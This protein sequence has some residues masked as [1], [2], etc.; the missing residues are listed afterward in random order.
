MIKK[1]MIRVVV[2][3]TVF[4]TALFGISKLMNRGTS[5]TTEE[6]AAATL[7]LVYMLHGDTQLNCLRGYVKTMDVIAMRD[8]LTPMDNERTV[9]IQVEKFENKIN[10]ISF[11]ILSSDGKKSLEN[12]KVTK[13]TEDENYVTATLELQNK[14]LINTEYIMKI[15][16]SVGNREIYY[17]TRII[18]EDG[19]HVKEYLDFV[20]GF[21]ERCLNK[22]EEAVLSA[23]IEPNELGD[24]TT[25]AHMDIHSSYDQLTWNKLNPQVYYKPIPSIREINQTTA[26]IVMDYMIST[27]NENN[28]TELYHVSEYYRMRFTESRIM[29]NNFERNTREIFNP[30]DDV[31]TREGINLGIAGK[32]LTY[33]N[34]ARNNFFAFVQEG[35]LWLYDVRTRRLAQVFSFPQ[36]KNLGVR[37]TY[38]QN[39]IQI[40]SIDTQGNVYFLVCGYMNRGKHEGESGVVVYYYDAAALNVKECLFVDTKRAYP[41]LKQDVAALSYVNKERDI[42]YI[43]I[44]GEVYGIHMETRQVSNLVSDLKSGCHGSSKSGQQ[45]AWMKEN[46][47]YNSKTIS[48]MDLETKRVREIS[49]QSGERL[50]ILGFIGEDLIYGVASESDIDITHN[51]NEIFPMN[52][53]L[54]VNPDGKTVKEYN[55]QGCY[56]KNVVI[57]DKLMTIKRMA[58]TNDG[59][60]EVADDQIVN[61]VADEETAF[62]YTT[63]VTEKKETETILT[64]GVTIDEGSVPQIVR[65]RQV[66]YEGSR[67]IVL[68]PKEMKEEQYFVYAKGVLDSMNSS[69]N[70]AVQRADAALGIVLNSKQQC[71]W[72]RGNTK[73]KLDLDVNSFPS[74]FLS[75]DLDINRL[76]S[77]MDKT[78]IDLSGCTLEQIRY[79]ISEGTPVMAKTPEG[80][81]LIGGYDEYNYRLLKQGDTELSYYGKNDSEEMF[82]AAGNI[83]VTYLDP[84]TE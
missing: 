4:L 70:I 31:L 11:E 15:A 36:E 1:V 45:F 27:T 78:V 23:A 7:P 61:S 9:M 21:Y 39:D 66:I 46:E 53:L 67:K 14:T 22:T 74:A 19:L 33:K 63:L 42:F 51:G 34:D 29:L 28:V 41:L 76:Q 54:I 3:L 55:P 24:N 68:E 20:T 62:G 16:L 2:L 58:N 43:M 32:N 59:Y 83:F 26:T 12:T 52:R 30:N 60:E 50:K 48:V 57:E 84:L 44:E 6:M 35:A 75:Y 47:L 72:E 64:V 10:G 65:S 73:V 81:V 25:F 80:V 17:Y 18:H 49:G 69:A 8:S 13:V 79:F 71:I 82:A 37:D 38:H 56:I 5:E 77:E 40:V